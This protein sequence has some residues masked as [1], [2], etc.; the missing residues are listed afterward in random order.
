M[1]PKKASMDTWLVL[2]TGISPAHHGA[3]VVP[4][5][6][7]WACTAEARVLKKFAGG[8]QLFRFIPSLRLNGAGTARVTEII[9]HANQ[10]SLEKHLYR[11]YWKRLPQV[12]SV[13]LNVT[14]CE[15]ERQ[16][17]ARKGR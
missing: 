16:A 4:V 8:M 2:G 9:H 6:Y 17:S 10:T 3:H 11:I 15:V 13:R 5:H 12:V 14:L 7:C 1:E